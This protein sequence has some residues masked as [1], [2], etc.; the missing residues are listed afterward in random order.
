MT[1]AT[2][3][4]PIGTLAVSR[5]TDGYARA[6]ARLHA[7]TISRGFLTR[8]GP[9]FLCQLYL[10]IAEDP[11]SAVF[12]ATDGG[13]VAGFLA[14]TSNVAGLYRRVVRARFG[15]LLLGMLPRILRPAVL[16]QAYD[17]LRYPAHKSKMQLPAAELLALGVDPQWQGRG[18]ARRLLGPMIQRARRDGQTH[19]SVV[20]GGA[21][22]AAN[23]FYQA[24]GFKLVAQFTHHHKPANAYVLT[25]PNAS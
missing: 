19:V 14:Y 6:V 22:E 15:R 21:L 4:M 18:V 13:R 24:N 20:A 5:L 17:T 3:H 23:H 2:V 12:V 25:I 11:D 10:G 9:R 7:A 1:T 16:W 8:L